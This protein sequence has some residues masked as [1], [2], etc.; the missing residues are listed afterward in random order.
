MEG[1]RIGIDLSEE[2]ID[3][4]LQ[5]DDRAEYAAF[6]PPLGQLG[7]DTFDSIEPLRRSGCEVEGPARMPR[8]PS[9]NLGMLVSGIVIGNGVD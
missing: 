1:P 6:Q 4:G 2:A 9:P 5:F 8:K 3:G 7:K